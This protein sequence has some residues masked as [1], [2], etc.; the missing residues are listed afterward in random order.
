MLRAECWN[1]FGNSW[2]KVFS[3]QRSVFS[4][5]FICH[6]TAL[7][8]HAFNMSYLRHEVFFYV[9]WCTNILSLKGHWDFKFA[10]Y[11]WLI[12]VCNSWIRGKRWS[13]LSNQL[14]VLC[15]SLALPR[16]KWVVPTARIL[17]L[18]FWCT[19]ILSLAGHWDF[20]FAEYWWLISVCNS[21]IRGRLWSVLKDERWETKDERF[22]EC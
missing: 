8:L 1:Q 21:W 15:D 11:W 12:S 18:F 10:E 20:N 6:L 9:F 5:Q 16:I 17:L 4:F 19:N 3:F 22:A 13:A 2:V 7:L 14:S